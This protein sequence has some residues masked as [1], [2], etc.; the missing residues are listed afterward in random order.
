M[1][2]RADTSTVV[3]WWRTIDKAMLTAVLFL[4]LAGMLLSF[5]ASP[6]VAER[7]GLDSFHFIKRHA[8]YLVL[9]FGAF[10]IA[11]FLNPTQVRRVALGLFVLSVIMLMATLFVGLEA[12]G[13]KRWL[14]ISGFT[15][16]PSEFIKPAFVVITAWLFAE[17]SR[18][19]DI[20]GNLF[21][22]IL[23]GIVCALL[24]AQPDFGQTMLV[25]VVWGAMFFLAGM[26]WI[27]IIVMG[28]LGI[29]GIGAG[30]V[31]FPHVA[32][33]MDRFITG[34]GD[35]FQ[36]DT[37]LQAIIHG[38][39]MGQGPGEGTVKR[40]L[41][42]GHSDFPFAVAAEEFG[43]ILAIVLVLVFSFIVLRG[44]LCA[45]R[46]RDAY[47]RLTTAGLIT[48][49]AIQSMIHL[50]VN[51]KLIPAKGMTL[52]FISY[53]GSSL[54]ASGIAMGFII[55]LTRQRPDMRSKRPAGFASG[56]FTSNQ[57]G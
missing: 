34:E 52:P 5:A 28:L 8:F 23:V 43:I 26:S 49:F 44:F 36:V 27:W 47:V 41:P 46:E 10:I 39:W 16:Q 42:D 7:I 48:M 25:A 50:S 12:K 11:S 22:I 56:N 1:I 24:I 6:P 20:P 21:S 55:A 14:L 2:S 18:R 15:I 29:G 40:I 4:M 51:L 3:E 54:L 53:G 32:G 9:A 33:R 31:F 45:L 17:N 30:Y 13:S 57:A 38:G 19:P 35:N 37:G